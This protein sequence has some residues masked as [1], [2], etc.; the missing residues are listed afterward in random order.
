MLLINLC[1]QAFS[2]SHPRPSSLVLPSFHSRRRALAVRCRVKQG[3]CPSPAG[4]QPL[5]GLKRKPGAGFAGVMSLQ[6]IA[7]LHDQKAK[8]ERYKQALD[9]TFQTGSIHAAKEFVDHSEYACFLE[10]KA[11]DRRGCRGVVTNRRLGELTA[12]SHGSCPLYFQLIIPYERH[13]GLSH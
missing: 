2:A 13:C 12:I 3:R 4:T 5:F 1:A 8:I 10:W 6:E 11:P 9:S 7:A